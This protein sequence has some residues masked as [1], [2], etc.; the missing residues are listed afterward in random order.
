VLFAANILRPQLK[1]EPIDNSDRPF[2]P[3]LT[4]KPNSLVPLVSQDEWEARNRLPA[5]METHL[6]GLGVTPR[7][8]CAAVTGC[9]ARV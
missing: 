5:A 7:K 2:I 9:D 8:Q 4:E 3:R 6:Q 1:F